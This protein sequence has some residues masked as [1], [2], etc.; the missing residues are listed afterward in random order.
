M[1]IYYVTIGRRGRDGLPIE[2]VDKAIDT[3]E[4]TEKYLYEEREVCVL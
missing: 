2:Q 4:E 3:V 1:D